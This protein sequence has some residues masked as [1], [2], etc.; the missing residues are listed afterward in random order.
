MTT[1][2]YRYDSSNLSTSPLDIFQKVVC[3]NFSLNIDTASLVQISTGVG[4]IGNDSKVKLVSDS[5]LQQM[6]HTLCKLI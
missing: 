3:D 6:L 4:T 5:H 2:I 1:C